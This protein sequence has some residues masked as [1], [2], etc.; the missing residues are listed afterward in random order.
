MWDRWAPPAL[1]NQ[2]AKNLL[3]GEREQAF[4]PDHY[5]AKA[6]QPYSATDTPRTTWTPRLKRPALWPRSREPELTG[7]QLASLGLK[8]KEIVHQSLPRATETSVIIC[9]HLPGVFSLKLSS[10]LL[11][12]GCPSRPTSSC[13]GPFPPGNGGCEVTREGSQMEAWLLEQ[14]PCAEA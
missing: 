5:K 10:A 4:T 12:K 14:Q 6:R 7:V 13:V 11:G 8:W 2:W 9:K 3:S 1:P